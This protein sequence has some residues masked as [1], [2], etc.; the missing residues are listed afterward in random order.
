M[1]SDTSNASPSG[2]LRILA[3][4]EPRDLRTL[5]GKLTFVGPQKKSVPGLVFTTF[6]HTARMDWFPPVAARGPDPSDDDFSA[7]HFTM[8]PEE[9]KSSVTSLA[10]H[11]EALRHSSSSPSPFLSLAMALKESRLGE[12]AFEATLDPAGANIVL[13][14]IDGS[15][16]QANGLAKTVM[17]LYRQIVFAER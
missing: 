3:S 12:H 2:I 5:Q 15:L 10:R 6:Y 8:T 9:M 13:D 17:E 11:D 1:T 16:S 14:A 4:G 7:W